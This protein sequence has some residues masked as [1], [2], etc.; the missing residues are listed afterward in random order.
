MKILKGKFNIIFFVILCFLLEFLLMYLTI[1]NFGIITNI[2]VIVVKIIFFFLALAILRY[3][4]HITKDL[5]GI[6]LLILSPIIGG[7]FI[8]LRGL[9]YTKNRFFKRLLNLEK[10]TNKY[11]IQDEN[12]LKEL[13]KMD[14][15]YYSQANYISRYANYPIYKN[16]L[17]N[18]YSIGEEMYNDILKELEK[19]T[20]FIFVEYFIIDEGKMWESILD[21]LKKK[22]SKGVDVRIIYDAIGC[23]TTLKK[24]YKEKLESC[25]IKCEVFNKLN[26]LFSMIQNHRDHRKILVIDGNTFFTGGTNLADEYINEKEKYGKWKDCGVMVKG[27]AV[28]SF[29]LMFLRNWD[30]FRNKESEYSSFKSTIKFEKVN[31]FIAPY[32]TNPYNSDLI[33]KNIYL[34]IINNS[35]DYLYIFTPYLILDSDMITSLSLAAKRGVDVKIVTPGIPN[36]KLIHFITR[37]YYDKL[38]LSGVKIY[39]Y[40]P[41]FVHSKVFVC[42]DVVATVGSLNLDYRSLY[43]DFECGTFFYNIDEIKNMKDDI[44]ETINKSKEVKEEDV[45]GN[46]FKHIIEA[47]LRLIAPLL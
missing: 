26:P 1:K 19:A 23:V 47:F 44:L 13:G 3:S 5:P 29:T 21:I 28:W 4:N 46:I 25:G 39:E 32:G 27:E 38:I 35:T 22:A 31:G 17:V 42:D 18:Y 33:G 30:S 36:S 37:S 7:I 10:S 43:L 11:L 8:M 20:K 2:L 9:S 41:G 14:N 16:S 6:V 12:V 40:I 34:N 24:G 45:K 15:T